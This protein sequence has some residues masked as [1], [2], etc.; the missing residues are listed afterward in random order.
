[1]KKKRLG[2]AAIMKFM[3]KNFM[4][5]SIKGFREVKKNSE[6]AKL[7]FECYSNLVNTQTNSIESRVTSPEPN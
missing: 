3:Q 5:N 2:T 1:M 6:N 7:F 4:V